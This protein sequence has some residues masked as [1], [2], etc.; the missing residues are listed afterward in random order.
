M[1]RSL[2]PSEMLAGEYLFRRYGATVADYEKAADEDSRLELL[3]GVLIMHSP[4]SVHH[5]H[6]FWFLGSLLRGYVEA[7]RL[8]RVF[9]SRTP[10]VLDDERRFEPDLLFVSDRNLARLGEVALSGPADLLIEILS[11]ATR[12]YDLGEKRQAYA[13]GHVPEYWVVDPQARLI[14]VDRPAGQRVLELAS[15]RLESP[16][17]P[18]FWLEVGWLWQD[19]LPEAG[20]C[21]AQILG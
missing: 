21:L 9:G 20:R 3:D 18:G 1:A 5:E 6:L 15:G 16:N 17:L 2:V 12:D 8:G 14:L 19:P 11:P 13:D 4:A 7:K 10:M